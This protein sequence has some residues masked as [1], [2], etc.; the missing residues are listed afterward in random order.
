MCGYRDGGL[1]F[2]S[3]GSAN[4]QAGGVGYQI[5]DGYT[6]SPQQRF[7]HELGS[8]QLFLFESGIGEWY[9]YLLVGDY[10]RHNSDVR[11]EVSIRKKETLDKSILFTELLP[12]AHQW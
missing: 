2:S 11:E 1:A 10:L 9:D 4:V 3:G 6:E 7:K 8:F 5:V 12:N